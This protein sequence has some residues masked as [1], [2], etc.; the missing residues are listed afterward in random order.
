M[1]KRLSVFVMSITVWGENGQLDE[2]AFRKHLR[3]IRDAGASTYIGSSGTGDGFAM[4]VEE[5]DRVLAI[6]SEE[7]R[8]HDGF[9]VMG[10]EPRSLAD[11]LRFI[12]LVE[13]HKPEALQIYPLDLGHSLKPSFKELEAYYTEVLDS[14]AMPIVL[15]NFDSLGFTLPL[16][17]IER[18]ASRH[19]NLIGFLYGGRDTHYLSQA[20]HRLKDRL[21]VHCAGPSNAMTTL[22]LGGN[23]F[24]G[25]EGNLSPAL[26]AGVINAFRKGDI[27]ELG[28]LYAKLMQVYAMHLPHGGSAGRAMKPLLNALGLPGGTLRAPRLPIS[29]QEL[30]PLIEATLR[31]KLPSLAA[32]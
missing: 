8:G 29:Q 9:R 17:L 12:R 4:S 10:C 13:P 19:T 5:W 3:R 31:L 28:S 24:M 23:G 22:M 30:E 32:G 6:V 26:V 15:S 1:S 18:L 20:L 7:F 27:V 14:T 25:H 21:E 16:D 11:V 2:G